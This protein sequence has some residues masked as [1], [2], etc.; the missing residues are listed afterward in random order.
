MLR[1]SI[2]VIEQQVDY[3]IY[4][5]C[6]AKAPKLPSYKEQGNMVGQFD[7]M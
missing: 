5:S 3:L 6:G 4:V 1:I 2:D 7:G